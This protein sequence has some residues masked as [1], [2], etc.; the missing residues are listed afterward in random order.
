MSASGTKAAFWNPARRR[1]ASVEILGGSGGR[2][3]VNLPQQLFSYLFLGF[4]C[5]GI[6]FSQFSLAFR[7]TDFNPLEHMLLAV[8]CQNILM[9]PI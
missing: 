1:T 8:L 3:D 6:D 5:V 9:M 4:V 2:F 7:E